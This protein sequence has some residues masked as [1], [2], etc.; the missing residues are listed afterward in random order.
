TV[1]NAAGISSTQTATATVRAKIYS[2]TIGATQAASSNQAI[3]TAGTT[4]NLFA[5]FAGSATPNA[6]LA[7]ATACSGT[8]PTPAKI[9]NGG[10]AVV[11]PSATGTFNYTLT[12]TPSAGASPVASS[13]VTV[14]VV[15]LATATS[16]TTDSTMIHGGASA[17]LTPDFS[18]NSAVVDG[19]ATI[20][21]SDGSRYTNLTPLSVVEVAPV[22]TTTYT[23]NVANVAGT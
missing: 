17:T 15:P 6:D 8:L 5:A 10:S 2:F 9:V 3:I 12:V 21:G 16:L 1:T 14:K 7:C 22:A 13:P 18:F 19:T 11:T 23:L 20:I 4:T